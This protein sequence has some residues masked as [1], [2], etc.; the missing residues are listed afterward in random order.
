MIRVTLTA[1]LFFIT[2][3]CKTSAQDLLK[4]AERNYIKRDTR[5]YTIRSLDGKNAKVLVMPDYEKHVL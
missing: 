4:T 1:C 5:S 2:F 3:N